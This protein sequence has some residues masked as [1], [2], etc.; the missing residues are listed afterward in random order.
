MKY[1]LSAVLIHFSSSQLCAAGAVWHKGDPL[2]FFKSW[3]QLIEVTLAS[4]VTIK[5]STFTY[6]Y[7]LKNP[8]ANKFPIRG[9][10]LD[11]RINP[12]QHPFSSQD[13]TLAHRQLEHIK[14]L[15]SADKIQTTNESALLSWDGSKYYGE[16]FD[17]GWG[18]VDSNDVLLPGKRLSGFTFSAD[19]PPGVREFVAHGWSYEFDYGIDRLSPDEFNFYY[20]SDEYHVETSKGI[21]C[22]GK[23]IAPVAPPE[24]FTVSSW[25]ARMAEYA[26][27]AR[28][29]KW[30]KTDKTLAEVKKLI[31]ALNTEDKGKLEAAVRKIGFY[32]LAEK[33][34]GNFTDEADALVRLNAWYLLERTRK[35]RK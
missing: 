25:T 32:S 22:L 6:F 20:N 2:P 34:K 3:P 5:N 31:G 12:E 13:I 21:Q 15:K 9:L 7:T 23:T 4:S 10:E 11:L 17:G 27:E 29:Q 8:S 30:I 19:F 1:L 26:I 18:A 35:D 28:K 33:K 16:V 14:I 24:P